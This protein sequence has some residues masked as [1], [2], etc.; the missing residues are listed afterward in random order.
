MTVVQDRD[1]F[2][3]RRRALLR[4]LHAGRPQYRSTGEAIVA[5]LLRRGGVAAAGMT[6]APIEVLD[7]GGRPVA[8]AL[9]VHPRRDPDR[10]QLACLEMQP[11]APAL[12]LLLEAARCAARERGAS[13]VVVGVNGHVNNG[14]GVLTDGFEQRPAFGEP[15]NAPELPAL[16]RDHACRETP[17]QT[18]RYDIDATDHI[19]QQRLLERLEHRVTFRDADFRH[20]DRELAAYTA[21]NNRCF[22]GHAYYYERTDAEDRELFHQMRPLLRPDNLIWAE[23]GGRPAGFL[24]WYPDFHERVGPGAGVNWGTALRTRLLRP[25]FD[26]ARVAELGVLPEH[27]DQGVAVGLIARFHQRVR[28]RFHRCRSGWILTENQRS[29]RLCRRWNAQPDRAFSVFE[30]AAGA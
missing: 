13:T 2:R 14:V 8:S 12:A 29:I 11:E 20:W 15:W 3:R 27:Q 28:G 23:I 10:L 26:T 4:T 30:L 25:S 16:I 5:L 22:R 17:L 21:L 9:C 6:V 24:L 1:G 18:F 7:A 19:A